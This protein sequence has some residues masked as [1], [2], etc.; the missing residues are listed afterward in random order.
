MP[1]EDQTD[2]PFII[3][4]LY[5]TE[6]NPTHFPTDV[7]PTRA[8]LSSDY[9][10]RPVADSA[11]VDDDEDLGSVNMAVKT[12]ESSADVDADSSSSST[13]GSSTSSSSSGGSSSDYQEA[14]SA[15]P[16]ELPPTIYPTDYKDV[17]MPTAFPTNAGDEVKPGL[18]SEQRSRGRARRRAD[19]RLP[20]GDS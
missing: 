7:V 20:R 3:P 18:A 14:P 15:F 8:F 19:E 17:H 5:P 13:S 11:V 10:D 16:T 6:R 1:S 4:T 9:T 2:A 12:V